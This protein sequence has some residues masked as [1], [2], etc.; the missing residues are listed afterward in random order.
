MV[1][2][3]HSLFSAS[4]RNRMGFLLISTNYNPMIYGSLS[5]KKLKPFI[6]ELRFPPVIWYVCV[7]KNFW[8]KNICN[9]F[10][11]IL[12]CFFV[13][14]LQC[15]CFL[16]LLLEV[17][18][19]LRH[20]T[21]FLCI[22]MCMFAN[23]KVHCLMD[24]AS[25]DVSPPIGIIRAHGNFSTL[26]LYILPWDFPT[27][28]SLLRT[29][30]FRMKDSSSCSNLLWFMWMDFCD[31]IERDSF[32]SGS[33]SLSLSYM[34]IFRGFPLSLSPHAWFFTAW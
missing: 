23:W 24:Y 13:S 27:L 3:V 10:S 5:W 26:S 17:N 15:G 22:C 32:A 28:F 6:L 34:P 7:K 11:C 30:F 8:K 21:C 2:F 33:I 19:S 29:C 18:F 16:F 9:H 20:G 14:P 1:L 25:N 31:K 12:S 4:L